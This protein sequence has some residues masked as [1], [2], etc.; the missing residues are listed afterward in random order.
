MRNLLVLSAFALVW[1]AVN[2]TLGRPLAKDEEPAGR[3][4][5]WV[6]RLAVTGTAG[7]ALLAVAFGF[8]AAAIWLAVWLLAGSWGMHLGRR[9]LI[10]RARLA[11]WEAG[12]TAVALGVAAWIG[13]EMNEAA[14]W[15]PLTGQN[16]ARLAVALITLAALLWAVHGGSLMVRGL[17]AK[18]GGA[19][20]KASEEG[21]TFRHGEII[22]QIERALVILIMLAGSPQ[23]LA[24]FFAAKGLIRSKELEDRTLADYFLLGS[25]ASFLVAIVCGLLLT[26]FVLPLWK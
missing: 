25:L 6:R 18:A 15:L 13:A 22:G 16:A 4:G 17:L 10:M 19:P 5:G 20:E 11:E 14:L 8:S 1:E 24:F 12:G 23:A 2:Y 9:R 7:A 3:W 26:N 21:S